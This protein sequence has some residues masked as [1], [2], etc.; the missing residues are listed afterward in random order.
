MLSHTSMASALFMMCDRLVFGYDLVEIPGSSAAHLNFRSRIL[1][2]IQ[3][4]RQNFAPAWGI[5]AY[6]EEGEATRG[7]MQVP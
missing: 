7:D 4:S 6:S 2:L 3:A 1:R 5:H